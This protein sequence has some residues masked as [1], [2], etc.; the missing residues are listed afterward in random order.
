MYMLRGSFGG[1]LVYMDNSLYL[2]GAFSM[3]VNGT[4]PGFFS[5]SC[6]LRQG[7]LVILIFCG[8]G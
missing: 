6:G 2:F 5:S 4:P 3:L 7:D 8:V 1:K